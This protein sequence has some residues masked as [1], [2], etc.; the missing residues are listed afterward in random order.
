MLAAK[1]VA[2]VRLDTDALGAAKAWTVLSLF[3]RDSLSQSP[4]LTKLL[5][6]RVIADELARVDSPAISA[7]RR[8]VKDRFGESVSAQA[9]LENIQESIIAPLAVAHEEPPTALVQEPS[10]RT[11]RSRRVP[12]SG[13]T[14]LIEAGLLPSDAALECTLYGVSHAARV[15]DGAIELE[16]KTYATPSAA[17]SALRDGKASN[18][19]VTW[20]YKGQ[21]LSD[22]RAKLGRAD[23]RGSETTNPA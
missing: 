5:V 15:H 9:V 10:T 13:L 17:A 1:H 19:W 4:P 11:V 21:L 16:G 8:A 23:Q 6:Q 22:L 20:K 14:E 3:S 12:R 18:G 2:H 7:L